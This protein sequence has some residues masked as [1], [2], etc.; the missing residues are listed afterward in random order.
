MGCN[1]HEEQRY[2]IFLELKN[3]FTVIHLQTKNIKLEQ[4]MVTVV[5]AKSIAL[6]NYC[7]RQ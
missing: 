6:H 2:A 1:F 7:F 5:Q 4:W 3:V